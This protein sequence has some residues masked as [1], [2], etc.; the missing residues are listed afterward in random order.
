MADDMGA[1]DAACYGSGAIETPHIDRL[2]REGM[3]FTEAHAPSAVCTP[4]R[5]SV[6]TGR[7]FFRTWKRYS[8]ISGLCPP[9]I[10]PA[11]MTTASLLRD[12]G[13]ATAAIGKWHLGMN[14][15]T[16]RFHGRSKPGG[17]YNEEA[18]DFTR[19]IYG[20]PTSVGFDRYFGISGSLNMAPH[21]FIDQDRTVGVPEVYY[22]SNRGDRVEQEPDPDKGKIGIGAESFDFS[23]VDVIHCERALEF[24]EDHHRTRGDQPF[25]L[26]LTPSAPHGPCVPPEFLDGESGISKRADMVR[27]LDW[28]VGRLTE[29]LERLGLDDNTLLIFTSDNGAVNA[30]AEETD[31]GHRANADRRG[32]KADIWDGGHREPMLVR[33]PGVVQPGS[34]CDQMVCLSDLP[35]TCAELTD[36]PLPSGA[37]EDSISFLPLLTRPDRPTRRD[38]I[39]QSAFGRLALRTD[40]YKFID[41]V[42][43]GNFHCPQWRQPGPDEPRGMLFD[44][45]EDVGEQQ[46][47]LGD[48]PG[49][50]ETMLRRLEQCIQQEHSRDAGV[51]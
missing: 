46:N 47:L 21:C 12:S 9:M 41:A 13:Y 7:Y 14:F 23:T 43:E 15:Q 50:G 48:Q 31:K 18:F 38:M 20:G 1:G 10:D 26:Y 16:K 25:F 19:P 33:W 30:G 32:Y 40:R 8:V 36:T 4:T 27:V 11:R 6:M 44:M 3:R 22:Y 28:M 39:N 37:G 5:Y 29:T 35:A 24:I 17:G 45:Q 34:V 51:S 49:R 2:A 42:D